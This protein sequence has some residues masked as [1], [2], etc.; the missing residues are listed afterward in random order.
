LLAFAPTQLGIR[1][2]TSELA[3]ASA[4]QL[5][6]ALRNRTIGS[7]ESKWG[8]FFGDWDLL[9]RPAATSVA[10]PHDHQGER[11]ERTVCANGK[12]APS[13]DQLFWAG[14][15]GVACLPATVA[16]VGLSPDGLPIGVQIVG[17]QYGD[18]SSIAFAGLLEQTYRGCV[19]PTR[20]AS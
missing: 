1:S 12:Q 2:P 5:D 14:I 3:F 9:L 18:R 15:L 6:A 17:P 4:T 7:R 11:W 13:T 8:A 16:S 19:P 20:F 10:F